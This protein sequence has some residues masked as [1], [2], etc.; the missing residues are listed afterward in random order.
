MS[1]EPD[2]P[3][4]E[5]FIR[6][7]RRFD[8][9]L[10]NGQRAHIR[11]AE[12][13]N[14]L[15][16]LPAYYHAL[17]PGSESDARWRRVVFM[18]PYA[19][20]RDGAPGL[21]ALLLVAKVS[22]LRLFQMVRSEEPQDILHLRRLCRHVDSAVDWRRFGPMLYYWGTKAKR[23]IVEDYFLPRRDYLESAAPNTEV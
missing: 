16:L 3:S 2:G 15:A 20:H 8:L 9:K 17:A 21:G 6:L 5:E 18:L 19:R 13:P 22:E 12:D 11:R 1:R 14:A 7:K 23:S 4:D 10:D